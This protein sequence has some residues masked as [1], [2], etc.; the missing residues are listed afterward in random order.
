MMR[1]RRKD[2]HTR[3]PRPGGR[4][5]GGQDRPFR[6]L[7]LLLL[8]G[9]PALLVAQA[10]TA[11]PSKRRASLPGSR[12]SITN[13]TFVAFDT[14][15]TGV[16]QATDRIVEIGAVKFRN[17]KVLE[18]KSWLVNPERDIPYWANRVHGITDK[19]V[20]NERTFPEVYPEFKSFIEG[21]VLLAH[22][23]RF[24]VTFMENSLERSNQRRPKNPVIDSLPL[25]RK[26]FPDSDSHTLEGLAMHLEIDGVQF[27]RAMA[28]SMFIYLILEKGLAAQDVRTLGSLQKAAGKH[29]T[30]KF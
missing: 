10:T 7:L 3:L 30:L 14:E 25:F 29:N 23:A 15:T 21:C 27:H 16:N 13:V 5:Q 1:T 24:D 17:G 20:E 22:N 6:L 19:M 8:A 18:Q 9:A 4:G 11:E 2:P 26:W 28:D 12:T